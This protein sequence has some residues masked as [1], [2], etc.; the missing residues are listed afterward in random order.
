VECDATTGEIPK[1]DEKMKRNKMQSHCRMPKDFA[2]DLEYELSHSNAHD[3]DEESA[4][5]FVEHVVPD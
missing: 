1:L 5:R 4:G 3:V 2:S